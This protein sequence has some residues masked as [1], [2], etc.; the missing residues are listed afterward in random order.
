MKRSI[1]IAFLFAFISANSQTNKFYWEEKPVL[2]KVPDEFND[3]S[4]V[5]LNDSRNHEY[6]F[7]KNEMWVYCEQIRK[8]KVLTDKGIEQFNKIYIFYRGGGEVMKIKAR[9]ISPNGEVVNLPENK[10]FDEEEDGDKFKKFAVEGIEKNSEIEYYVLIRYPVYTFGVETYMFPSVPIVNASFSLKIPSHLYFD[11]KGYNG[12]SVQKDTV[13]DDVR[14]TRAEAHNIRD[15]ESEKYSNPGAHYANVQYK[16]SYN[17]DKNSKVRMNTWNEFAK[18]VFENYTVFNKKE[19]KAIET[20][21]KKIDLKN[22]KNDEEK[23]LIIE[24]YLKH[25]ITVNK[26]TQNSSADMLDFIVQ[27]K[28]G[29]EFGFNRLMFGCL[30]SAGLNPRLV[31]PSNRNEKPLDENFENFRLTNNML[32]FFPST[33]KYLSPLSDELRYPIINPNDGATKGLFIKE[34]SL[35]DYKSGTPV[36]D[37]ITLLPFEESSSNMEVSLSFN[38]DADT[39]TVNSKQ[40]LTGYSA[41]NYRPAYA[42]LQKKDQDEFTKGIIK[43]VAETDSILSFKVENEGLTNSLSNKPLIISG[44]FKNTGLIENAGKNILVKIGEVIGTQ[45]QMYQEKKRILPIS[46]EY[47]HALD[48][49]IKF[50]IPAGYKLKNPDDIN[51]SVSDKEKTMGFESSYSLKGNDLTITVHEYYK[52]IGYPV[53]DIEIFTKVINAAADFN[54]LTLVLI[55]E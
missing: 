31:F 32:L 4:A 5:L 21:L 15:F 39:L 41:A 1:L 29:G 43:N 9:A 40:I 44:E 20:I 26:N 10:I 53:E 48:R 51:A 34:I 37:S 19:N 33:G 2:S 54:K 50:K 14:I 27:S 8:I 7:D 47:P 22:A 18:N 25:N 17:L 3:A 38:K 49:I 36:F 45:V 30:Q 13:I 28:V 24:D 35:S 11:V 42:Y 23:I 6:K 46:L 12:F 16:L 55:R 52:S